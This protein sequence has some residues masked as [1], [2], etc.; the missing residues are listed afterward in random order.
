MR[1]RE[2]GGLEEEGRV[3]ASWAHIPCFLGAG[4]L[5]ARVSWGFRG[6]V[7]KKARESQWLHLCCFFMA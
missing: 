2:E 3:P 7:H 1:R 5:A 6:L 4:T